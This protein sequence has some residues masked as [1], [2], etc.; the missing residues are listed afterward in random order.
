M[1][2][3]RANDFPLRRDQQA[4]YA[5]IQRPLS[6]I[7]DLQTG[8]LAALRKAA[9]RDAGSRFVLERLEHAFDGTETLDSL[10]EMISLLEGLVFVSKSRLAAP[11]D[12]SQAV[13]HN[14]EGGGR[15]HLRRR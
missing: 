8:V 5:E 9:I 7:R 14:P 6:A 12:S 11:D 2:F 3:L 13:E 1:F 15:F 4:L 10:P